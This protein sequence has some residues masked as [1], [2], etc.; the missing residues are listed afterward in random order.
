LIDVN[1][2][3]ISPS[4]SVFTPPEGKIFSLPS[5][6]PQKIMSPELASKLRERFKVTRNSELVSKLKTP[7]NV[8]EYRTAELVSSIVS[9]TNRR[10]EKNP[11]G[12][13]DLR[14]QM[15]QGIWNLYLST[16]EKVV[17][18]D[19]ITVVLPTREGKFE[20]AKKLYFGREYEKGSLLELLYAPIDP[21]LLVASPEELGFSHRANS[22]KI[23]EFLCWLGVNDKPRYV[24]MDIEEGDFFDHVISSLEYPAQFGEI[25]VQNAEKLKE[26]SS[27]WEMN[28]QSV[29]RLDKILERSDPHAVIC[30][31]A[32]NQEDIGRWRTQGDEK[33]SFKIWPLRAHRGRELKHQSIPSYPMWLL[34]NR[35]W[36]LVEGG[37]KRPPN[38]CTLARRIPKGLS[39]IIGCPAFDV[40][41]SLVEKLKL[42][43]V[44]IKTALARVG[45]VMELDDLNWDSFYEILLEL[46]KLYPDG[47]GVKSIYRALIS[48]KGEDTPEGLGYKEFL[49]KGKMFGR[50]GEEK[51]YY[52]I[53]EL[54]YL[55]NLT[56]PDAIARH[57]PVLELDPRSGV[58]K[59]KKI[60]GVDQL[61]IDA[62]QQR[63]V[64]YS[65]HSCSRNFQ[66]DIEQLKRYIYAMRVEG[67]TTGREVRA[68]KNLRV[69]LCESVSA[70][71]SVRGEKKNIELKEGESVVSDSSEVH[72]VAD[73]K[74]PA[75]PLKDL[76]ISDKIGGIITKFLK[77]DMSDKIS[78]FARCSPDERTLLLNMFTGG[79]G[80]ER[81]MKARELFET[82]V[83]EEFQEP[84]P[85]EPPPP[86]VEPK[87]Q[88]GL[89][90]E[91]FGG[92][93]TE[94][95]L[96]GGGQDEVEI[97]GEW[98]QESEEVLRS[99]ARDIF[100]KG[101]KEIDISK[102]ISP[103]R[104]KTINRPI[105][106]RPKLWRVAGTKPL[107]GLNLQPTRIGSEE[108]LITPGMQAPAAD[109]IKKLKNLLVRI[110][111]CL[112]ADPNR[113]KLICTDTVTEGRELPGH[114][115]FIGFNVALADRS[116]IF[117]I[118]IAARELAALQYKKHYPHVK[119]MTK[120][121]EKALEHLREIDP[122]FW[123]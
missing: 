19:T 35:E 51:K 14:S 114:P 70:T 54:Y 7:F 101:R 98:V 122:G 69:I 37:D 36:L 81:L 86:E 6:M 68:L 30:W 65:E 105:V 12:E 123:E 31:V 4:G 121:I 50:M 62:A 32:T 24:R 44:E 93:P 108:V 104:P 59:V 113:I 34:E 29:D 75:S 92:T 46:P 43:K 100:L 13:L 116:P 56:L 106:T 83:E 17:L 22:E 60:F 110:V 96:M 28:V 79:A 94:E 82:P 61:T 45:V 90:G 111:S 47:D 26:Y 55:E 91:S 80:E 3:I 1:N 27:R 5:W 115:G 53:R 11:V 52:P 33:A 63:I 119:A 15:V 18:P 40:N 109:E 89:G 16:D 74:D 76:V 25:S 42:G 84:P 9:E 38:K 23:E 49:G 39:S 41:H 87:E 71:I 73:P 107:A 20:S 88:L 112:G 118:I 64:D 77:V 21:N 67:D 102:I 97:V 66:E 8:R 103:V 58:S 57:Y 78:R 95:E 99:R 2:N 10:A 117:W 72:L 85:W 120:L 48:S